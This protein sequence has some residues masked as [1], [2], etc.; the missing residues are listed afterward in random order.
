MTSVDDGPQA[1]I[2]GCLPV[3]P[4]A[5]R[6]MQAEWQDF[7]EPRAPRPTDEK[8]QCEAG[9]GEMIWASRKVLRWRARA[10]QPERT[11]L[12]CWSCARSAVTPE[13]AAA[14]IPLPEVGL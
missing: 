11:S 6:R 14:A 13:D 12:Y 3:A 2:V 8:M 10:P 5:V 7:R 1:V 4:E 9:C